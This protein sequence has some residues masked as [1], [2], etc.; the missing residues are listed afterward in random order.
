MNLR[1][2]AG[3]AVFRFKD[4]SGAYRLNGGDGSLAVLMYHGLETDAQKLAVRPL[5]IHPQ[6]CLDEIRFFVKQG[7]QLVSP[8]ELV[9]SN[10]S[11]NYLIVSFDDGHLNM[12]PHLKQWMDDYSIPVTLAVCPDIIETQT[13]FWW[14]E[15]SARLALTKHLGQFADGKFHSAQQTDDPQSGRIGKGSKYLKLGTHL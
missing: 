9:S 2:F 14:E 3:D 10:D 7:Y 12:L 8:A 4:L 11:G 1:R 15:A 5:D 6:H 13:V